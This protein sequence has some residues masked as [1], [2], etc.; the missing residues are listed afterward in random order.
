M[1]TPIATRLIC[2]MREVM[3]PC[4]I[5]P[6]ARRSIK[7]I[8]IELHTMIDRAHGFHDHHG[9]CRRQATDKRQHG[10]QWLPVCHRQGQHE[11]ITVDGLPL[12]RQQSCDGD[13]N[14][15][16]IDHHQ[17]ERKRPGCLADI[18]QRSVLNDRQME[19]TRQ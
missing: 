10:Q 6:L 9:G 1:T 5:W 18:V 17:V 15:E 13:R 16:N 7:G 4:H 8:T 11:C 3:S 2:R 19:L 14:D 12:E